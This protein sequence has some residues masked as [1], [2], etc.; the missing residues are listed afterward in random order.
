LKLWGFFRSGTSH[1]VRIGLNLKGLSYENI[2]VDLRSEEHLAESFTSINP[3]GLVPVL[4]VEGKVMTQSMAIL[5]W[6]E[7]RYPE[8]SLLPGNPEARARVRAMACIVGC[9]I[10]PVNNRRILEALRKE[11]SLDESMINAW[12][13]RWISA[14]FDAIETMLAEDTSRGEFCHC[15]A[16]T[17]A[18]I[19]VVSQVESK[20]QFLYVLPPVADALH[21]R[22]HSSTG[23]TRCQLTP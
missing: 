7:E 5:E 22:G 9:D 4:A 13:C 14:G 3:Q 18:D 11:F 23:R 17:M 10:H 8:P 20:R 15:G 6:L 19:Y 12:A 2:A 16:P 1:R 21:T